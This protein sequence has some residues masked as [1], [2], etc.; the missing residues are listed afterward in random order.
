MVWRKMTTV[1]TLMDAYLKTIREDEVTAASTIT[2]RL[3]LELTALARVPANEQYSAEKTSFTPDELSAY[4]IKTDREGYLGA[5]YHAAYRLRRLATD[6]PPET[7]VFY[8]HRFT[9]EVDTFQRHVKTVEA[10]RFQAAKTK[11]LNMVV[12]SKVGRENTQSSNSSLEQIQF[13]SDGRSGNLSNSSRIVPSSEDVEKDRCS[14]QVPNRIEP[15]SLK[16]EICRDIAMTNH[17]ENEGLSVEDGHKIPDYNYKGPRKFIRH[18]REGEVVPVGSSRSTEHSQEKDT[19]GLTVL[20]EDR[21]PK[22]VLLS[23]KVKDCLDD[24]KL[25]VHHKVFEL[26]VNTGCAP[27]SCF[28]YLNIGTFDTHAQDL[29]DVWSIWYA[30]HGEK[31][32]PDGISTEDWKAMVCNEMNTFLRSKLPANDL[33]NSDACKAALHEQ[34]DWYY[35]NFRNFIQGVKSKED[36]DDAVVHQTLHPIVQ[37]CNR[38]HQ[39]KGFHVGGYACHPDLGS[40][41]WVGTEALERIKAV[42]GTQFLV[43]AKDIGRRIVAQDMI[44]QEIDTDLANLRSHCEV[45][46]DTRTRNRHILP[47]IFTFDAKQIL[48]DEKEAVKL[49]P[50]HFVENAFPAK[51]RIINWPVGVPFYKYGVQ[52]KDGFVAGV[53]RITDFSARDLSK[54]CVPCIAEIERDVKG[55]GEPYF[56]MKSWTE[57]EK[58]LSLSDQ[59]A[60]AL[61]SDTEGTVIVK[62][63][64]SQSYRHTMQQGRLDRRKSEQDETEHDTAL[65]ALTHIPEHCAST[66]TA[67]FPQRSEVA[68]TGLPSQ[69]TLTR[70]LMCS[71]QPPTPVNPHAVSKTVVVLPPPIQKINRAQLHR[72]TQSQDDEEDQSRPSKKKKGLSSYDNS[73]QDAQ[74]RVQAANSSA[75]VIAPTSK[76]LVSSST[77]TALGNSQSARVPSSRKLD[78][79]VSDSPRRRKS[80]CLD[81][82]DGQ[83]DSV[84]IAQV[85]D[86]RMILA[87]TLEPYTASSSSRYPKRTRVPSNPTLNR[88]PV[89][90]PQPPTSASQ[91]VLKKVRLLLPPIEQTNSAPLPCIMRSRDGDKDK[92]GSWKKKRLRNVSRELIDISKSASSGI[93]PSYPISTVLAHNV[94]SV[95]RDPNVVQEFIQDAATP[96]RELIAMKGRSRP[97]VQTEASD[98]DL[99]DS[100]TPKSRSLVVVASSTSS[101]SGAPGNSSRDIQAAGGSVELHFGTIIPSYPTPSGTDKNSSVDEDQCIFEGSVQA[102]TTEHE[103][104]IKLCGR[105]HQDTPTGDPEDL[106]DCSTSKLRSSVVVASSTSSAPGAPGNS[107]RDIQAAGGSVE[108]VDSCGIDSTLGNSNL[109]CSN[110]NIGWKENRDGPANTSVSSSIEQAYPSSKA[111]GQNVA[112]AFSNQS[113]ECEQDR[114]LGV[115]EKGESSVCTKDRE[116][117]AASGIMIKD[118]EHEG[119]GESSELF[120][121]GSLA[122]VVGKGEDVKTGTDTNDNCSEELHR[123]SEGKNII[124]GTKYNENSKDEV[125]GEKVVGVGRGKGRTKVE[126]KEE[127]RSDTRSN[128]NTP[129]LELTNRRIRTYYQYIVRTYDETTFLAYRSY[130]GLNQCPNPDIDDFILDLANDLET[131]W[132]EGHPLTA[133]ER[134]NILNRSPAWISQ[135]RKSL[136]PGQVTETGRLKRWASEHVE[137]WEISEHGEISPKNTNETKGR[138]RP[139][140]YSSGGHQAGNTHK[141]EEDVNGEIDVVGVRRSDVCEGKNGAVHTRVI[142]EGGGNTKMEGEKVAGVDREKGQTKVGTENE[143]D[144]RNDS[145]DNRNVPPVLELTNPRIHAYYMYIVRT[146]DEPT[147]LAYRTYSGLNWPPNPDIDDFILEL[148][149]DLETIWFEGRPLTAAERR[150]ILNRSPAWI[151]QHRKLLRQDQVTKNGRLKRWSPEHLE[152]RQISEDGEVSA[153]NADKTK[154]H[155]GQKRN[156]D[157]PRD[158]DQVENTDKVKRQKRRD[159]E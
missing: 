49:Q 114:G 144:H 121:G 57:D 77:A 2:Y 42:R 89:F 120:H 12:G 149:N 76:P 48:Q 95:N 93:K 59:A 141:V 53:N 14:P 147:F 10:A 84:L 104:H 41:I 74:S 116:I 127:Q 67:T 13:S 78:K 157:E 107:S 131:I 24:I 96:Y 38:L 103:N 63:A 129:A 30:V 88:K 91:R 61:V 119:S 58:N 9:E 86:P 36:R 106:D 148:A 99:D 4:V 3:A 152:P 92:V 138:K 135:Q 50:T 16:D 156:P 37:M 34:F 85:V 118:T 54:I 154:V 126:N 72:R 142:N 56:E 102:C 150:N 11:I 97:D 60:L 139:K 33:G 6:I 105:S 143:E 17:D 39:E 31:K 47:L 98:Q 117:H 18:N 87:P 71:P 122:Q 5:L 35:E 27:H 80:F 73:E 125:E 29:H 115:E 158:G 151:S 136:R 123:N 70:K 83:D 155:K 19:E 81:D 132:F 43:R 7:C 153:R 90:P 109:V 68:P 134:R 52:T 112:V 137:L 146:H 1:K 46:T 124:L 133:T 110:H 75:M 140:R 79:D 22:T 113:T 32:R 101:A 45:Q 25:K 64:D 94:A 8:L 28:R 23:R 111:L 26:A 100:T 62:V 128:Q 40:Y 65:A 55:Q 130:S 44:S 15:D 82:E 145:Q 66:A 108:L 51:V 69:T 20:D 159:R 21:G